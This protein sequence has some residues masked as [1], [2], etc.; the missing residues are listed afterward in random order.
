MPSRP[1]RRYSRRVVVGRAAGSI[2]HV[3]RPSAAGENKPIQV[4]RSFA[5]ANNQSNILH[6]VL[7]GV[8]GGHG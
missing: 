5:R 1:G 6:L 8:A 3:T 4:E 7:N 2:G